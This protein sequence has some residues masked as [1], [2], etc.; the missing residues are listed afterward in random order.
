MGAFSLRTGNRRDHHRDRLPQMQDGA[1]IESEN[2]RA[3]LE[4]IAGAL[5]DMA[6]L[7]EGAMEPVTHTAV[8]ILGP[9]GVVL[10]PS[11]GHGA[12]LRR[13]VDGGY[14]IAIGDA[15]PDVRWALAHELGHLGLRTLGKLELPPSEEESAANYIAGALLAPACTFRRAV[16]HFGGDL[17]ALR[18]LAKTFGLSQT[19]AQL[20]IGE[21]FNVDRAVVT[22]K[23]ENVLARGPRW[24]RAALTE[25][26]ALSPRRVE[27]RQLRG[28]I[29]EGRLAMRPR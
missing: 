7:D 3:D 9:D 26:R 29:D 4:M 16:K 25:L 27:R 21:V 24:G 15:V 17:T 28:G 11:L 10:V 13:R 22:A 23:Q 2:M 12:F 8:R 14:Q 18:P 1:F 20:R 19:S 6:G 5:R